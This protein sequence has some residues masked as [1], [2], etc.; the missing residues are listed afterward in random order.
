[1]KFGLQVK[2]TV[3]EVQVKTPVSQAV[4]LK[5]SALRKYPF[6]HVL[7]VGFPPLTG[8]EHSK[9]LEMTLQS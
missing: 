1:M 5:V 2:G 3:A 4:Q 6:P 7:Q 9:Q 8:G